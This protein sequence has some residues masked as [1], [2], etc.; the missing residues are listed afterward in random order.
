MSAGLSGANTQPDIFSFVM[1][2]LKQIT[3]SAHRIIKYRRTKLDMMAAIVH[4]NPAV[5]GLTSEFLISRSWFIFNQG[6]S[7]CNLG[8]RATLQD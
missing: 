5:S 4:E 2:E 3:E 8:C 7:H 1:E 6:K